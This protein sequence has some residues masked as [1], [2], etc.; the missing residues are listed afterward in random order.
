MGP[1]NHSY[2][3]GFGCD[4]N[5]LCNVVSSVGMWCIVLSYGVCI[6]VSFNIG[7]RCFSIGDSGGN[8]S[9]VCFVVSLS[10]W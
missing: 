6:Y 2:V 1:F 5:V 3:F 7:W 9:G 8:V 10:V 4:R